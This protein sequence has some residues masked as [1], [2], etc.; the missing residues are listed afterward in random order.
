MIW[1]QLKECKRG[2]SKEVSQVVNALVCPI[3]I[4][5]YIALNAIN[6]V[7]K[8]D[9]FSLTQMPDTNALCDHDGLELFNDV[10]FAKDVLGRLLGNKIMLASDP[11]TPRALLLPVG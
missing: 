5:S 1:L 2:V 7:S 11:H 4:G 3:N 9:T 6:N 8:G 10:F